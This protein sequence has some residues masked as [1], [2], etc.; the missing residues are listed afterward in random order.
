MK[1]KTNIFSVLLISFFLISIACTNTKNQPKQKIIVKASNLVTKN[2]GVQGMTCVGCEVT[3]EGSLSKIKGVVKVK[4]SASKDEAV[5]TFD[6]TKT[7]EL[8]II[9]AIADAGYKPVKS[10]KNK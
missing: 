5:I 9:K 10:T 4:A 7:D 1:N 2:I 8:S 3:L 6:K